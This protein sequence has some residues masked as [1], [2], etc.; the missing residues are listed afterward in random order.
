MHPL[1]TQV[2]IHSTGIVTPPPPPQPISANTLW[3]TETCYQ[4]FWSFR[5]HSKAFIYLRVAVHNPSETQG[6]RVASNKLHQGPPSSNF[7]GKSALHKLYWL[8]YQQPCLSEDLIEH[9]MMWITWAGC[10]SRPTHELHL[11]L[12]IIVLQLELNMHLVI[13][14]LLNWFLPCSLLE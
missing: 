5:D 9:S 7:P 13:N 10:C 12:C 1:K 11:L 8:I 2:S 6:V 3:S 14:S 4:S